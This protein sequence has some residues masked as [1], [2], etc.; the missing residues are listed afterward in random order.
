MKKRILII[1]DNVD[2]RESST[3]ILELSG[4]DVLQAPDGK[5]GVDLAF[6]QLPDLILCDIMMPELDG[7]GVLYLLHKNPDTVNIPFIFLTAKAERVDI[8]KGMEMG[9]DDY[10]TKP[11]DDMELL[12]AVER[13]LAKQKQQQTYYS[14]P[15]ES[16]GALAATSGGLTQLQDVIAGLKIRQVKK[17][18]D[19]YQ[20]EDQPKGIYLIMSGRV[21][22]S[23]MADD[24]RELITG[25]YTQNEYMGIEALLLSEPYTDNATAME[26]SSFCLLPKATIDSFLDRFTDVGQKFIHILSQNIRERETQLL[27]MAYH[28]VRKRMANVLVSLAQEQK[29]IL[30]QECLQVSREDMASMAGMATE[31]VSRILSDF[32]CEKLI[33]KKG[34]QIQIL[35]LARLANIKN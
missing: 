11:F 29:A 35:D 34:R 3:E 10:L 32:T 12:V 23:K 21:K 17:G 22:T 4:Y 15:L 30:P 6:A 20:V 27:Q 31:T 24:G 28:S 14:Q 16:L 9:A 8:R 13:R 25:M 2:I 18:Q 5:A 33:V 1:E 7:F 26:N 19:I